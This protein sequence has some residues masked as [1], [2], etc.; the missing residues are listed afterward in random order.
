MATDLCVKVADVVVPPRRMR[1]ANHVEELAESIR[2]IGLLHRITLRKL[3]GRYVL[4]AGRRRLEAFKLLK[5]GEIPARVIDAGETQALKVEIYENL[6]RAELNALERAD[7][8]SE[9][10]KIW[11]AEHPETGHGKSPGAGRGKKKRGSPKGELSSSL[12]P[13]PVAFTKETAK[14]TSTTRRTVEIY[15]QIGNGLSSKTKELLRGTPVEDKRTE[16]LKIARLP[17]EEQVKIARK[18]KSGAKSVHQAKRSVTSDRIRQE[19]QPLPSGPFR[20]IVAD[21]PWNYDKRPNDYTKRENFDYPTMTLEEIKALPVGDLGAGESILWLWSTNAHL[22]NAFEVASAW[23]FTYRTLLTWAKNK[24]GVG[25]WLRGQTEH[26][27]LCVRGK[28]PV[29]L[30][31]QSTILYAP[32]TKHSEK[33]DA[34]YTLI[35]SLCPGSKVE[36]FSRKKREGWQTWGSEV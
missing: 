15:A 16:L 10:K 26:C 25:E 20:V 28:A 2:D 12:G 3:D 18:I 34:F 17:K 33:P 29:E 13:E 6:Q 5:E 14:Q 7:H 19:P 32:V 9:L 27:L 35:E 24:L 31:S 8:I 11:E 21:P 22:P 30:T 1:T 4:V 36:L 23:G